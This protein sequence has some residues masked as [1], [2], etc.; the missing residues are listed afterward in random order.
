MGSHMGS[1]MG[2]RTLTT[3]GRRYHQNQ[4]GKGGDRHA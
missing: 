2:S 1:H 4:N 3:A